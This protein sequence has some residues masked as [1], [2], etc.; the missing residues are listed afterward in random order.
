MV[1]S[2]SRSALGSRSAIGPSIALHDPAATAEGGAT[3]GIEPRV[4]QSL[5]KPQQVGAG[6]LQSVLELRFPPDAREPAPL[7]A[8]PSEKKLFAV[9]DTVRRS[10]NIAPGIGLGVALGWT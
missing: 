10:W 6:S 1:S 8:K 3:L 5:E 7:D 9:S 2:S 4:D